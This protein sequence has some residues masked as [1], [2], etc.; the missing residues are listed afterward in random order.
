MCF[1]G[2]IS[3][4]VTDNFQ[5]TIGQENLSVGVRRKIENDKRRRNHFRVRVAC[6]PT[7]GEIRDQSETMIQIAF[8]LDASD[9][10]ISFVASRIE[11]NNGIQWVIA[12]IHPI[13]HYELGPIVKG[14]F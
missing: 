10:D 9:A 12:I 11:S 4:P 5:I 14:I 3:L 2:K 8:Q 6:V 7:G 1:S 13:C